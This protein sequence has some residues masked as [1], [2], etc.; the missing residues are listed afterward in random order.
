[1]K[2]KIIVIGS[3]GHAGVVIAAIERGGVCEIAGLID[4]FEEV[5]ISCHGYTILGHT[6]DL[7]KLVALYDTDRVFLAVG[8]SLW[9]RNF[10]G[11]PTVHFLKFPRLVDPSA[12]IHNATI[13]E[14][15][16]VAPGAH[17]GPG[18]HVG[19]FS[20]VNTHASL[21]HDSLLGD[22]SHLCPG[23]VT[24]GCVTIGSNTLIGVG[25][26]IRDHVNIGANC[27]IGM[28]SVVVKDVPDN[29]TGY[30]NPFRCR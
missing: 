7:P 16:F 21:D 26:M 3:G 4:D 12:D 8:D 11:A 30:G 13:G 20:I 10:V 22:F 1:M 28:G 23:V 9:R 29:S 19:S 17:L 27:V 15:S 14:G 24:G 5:G 18:C 25:A 6:L 2:P